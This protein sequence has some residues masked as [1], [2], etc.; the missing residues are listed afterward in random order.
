MLR[1]ATRQVAEAIGK[2]RKQRHCSELDVA[3]RQAESE[4][5]YC[6]TL[7]VRAGSN[8]VGWGGEDEGESE[9]ERI[10]ITQLSF[11]CSDGSGP[12]ECVVPCTGLVGGSDRSS[13]A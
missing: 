4:L 7:G 5:G 13:R 1:G 12:P 10:G 11:H 8:G 2:Q 6:A 9:G 3:V